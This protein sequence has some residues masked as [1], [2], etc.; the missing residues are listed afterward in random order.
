M[1]MPVYKQKEDVQTQMS[2][3]HY[4]FHNFIQNLLLCLTYYLLVITCFLLV[5]TCFLFLSFYFSIITFENSLFNLIFLTWV[6]ASFIHFIFHLFILYFTWAFYFYSIKI[7]FVKLHVHDSWLTKTLSCTLSQCLQ[8]FIS[9]IFSF[10]VVVDACYAPLRGSLIPFFDVL[11]IILFFCIFK[12]YFLL[13]ISCW[14]FSKL[15]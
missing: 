9:K 15:F 7:H 12:F 1:F 10:I 11:F 8:F 5:I 3:W 6:C 2:F 13:F 14:H 4:S